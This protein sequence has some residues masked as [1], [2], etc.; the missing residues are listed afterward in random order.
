M[1]AMAPP[2][3]GVPWAEGTVFETTGVVSP[4]HVFLFVIE[5]IPIQHILIVTTS[6]RLMVSQGR[7]WSPYHPKTAIHRMLDPERR[8]PRYRTNPNHNKPY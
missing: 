6:C 3:P 2:F 4:T 1:P 5:A 7:E 8:H